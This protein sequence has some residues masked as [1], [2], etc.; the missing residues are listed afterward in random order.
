MG[1]ELPEVIYER[2]ESQSPCQSV[3]YMEETPTI[4][5]KCTCGSEAIEVQ[6]WKDD[7]DLEFYFS[8]WTEGF[9]HPM[10]WRERL[11]WCW[12]VLTTG[13]PWADRII[14]NSTQ[15]KRIADFINKHHSNG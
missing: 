14:L 13:N 8:Y 15:A 6:Y 5:E 3:S 11:R 10:C 9:H 7:P 4:M 12:R 2:R 1:M